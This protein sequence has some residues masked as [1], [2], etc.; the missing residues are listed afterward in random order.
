MLRILVLHLCTGDAEIP[1]ASLLLGRGK[2]C[3]SLIMCNIDFNT[4]VVAC[5]ADSL[6]T[7]VSSCKRAPNINIIVPK[8]FVFYFSCVCMHARICV[9]VHVSVFVYVQV[10]IFT[11]ECRCLQKPEASNSPRTG[12]TSSCDPPNMGAENRTLSSGNAE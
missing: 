4:T 7:V 11:H 8:H 9:H 12:L 10:T 6:G 2:I 3:L 5:V 1:F